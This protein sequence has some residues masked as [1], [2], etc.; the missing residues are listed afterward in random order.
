MAQNSTQS[1]QN[2]HDIDLQLKSTNDSKV[3]IEW[4]DLQGDVLN[5]DPYINVFHK[6]DPSRPLFTH[7][8]HYDKCGF[9]DTSIS[10]KDG[11]QLRLVVT[12]RSTVNL[13]NGMWA[14]DDVQL[15]LLSKKGILWAH[16][17]LR[18]G[19]IDWKKIFYNSWVGL[20][21]NQYHSAQKYINY[22][23]FSN[24]TVNPDRGTEDY[25]VYECN[26]GSSMHTGIQLRFFIENQK[27]SKQNLLGQ[28]SPLVKRVLCTTPEFDEANGEPQTKLRDF[29][30]SLQLFKRNQCASVRLYIY[31]IF[32]DWR[33]TFRDAWVA[34]YRTP[35]TENSQWE[36]WKFVRNFQRNRSRETSDYMVYEHNFSFFKIEPGVQARFFLGDDYA[37][38]NASTEPWRGTV[39]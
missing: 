6:S 21:S 3:R 4:S 30:A 19:T 36:D 12:E 11:P 16:L 35:S 10:L 29:H 37:T 17:K 25:V 2:P 27:I 26:T 38:I 8:V 24:F 33:Q 14:A 5:M 22:W 32:P 20:Y 34:V 39:P 28:T 18:K 15:T 9:K 31:N 23:W 7:F 1:S 13:S